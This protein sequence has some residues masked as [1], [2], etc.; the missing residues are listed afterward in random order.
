MFNGHLLAPFVYLI[1]TLSWLPRA[2]SPR[3]VLQVDTSDPRTAS[4]IFTLTANRT[5]ILEI[6]NCDRNTR[7]LSDAP[8]TAIITDFRYLADFH[9]IVL[10]EQS[11]GVRGYRVHMFSVSSAV[12]P[13]TKSIGRASYTELFSSLVREYLYSSSDKPVM[14]ANNTDYLGKDEYCVR[15]LRASAKSGFPRNFTPG[16]TFAGRLL[17]VIFSGLSNTKF[18]CFHHGIRYTKLVLIFNFNN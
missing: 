10:D 2:V 13:S 6:T 15:D 14:P 11:V 16:D 3:G 8:V 7:I 9:D 17:V 12:L 18:L 1:C 5:T 4:A